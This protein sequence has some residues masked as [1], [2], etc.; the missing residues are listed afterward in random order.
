MRLGSDNNTLG[1]D[2]VVGEQVVDRSGKYII[3]IGA[4]SAE[5]FQDLLNNKKHVKFIQAVSNV[6][7]A[8]PLQCDIVLVLDEGAAQPACLGESAYS[9]LGQST[10]LVSPTNKQT[11]S[12]VL[13]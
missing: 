6:F 8:Q 3:R 10:W 12:V 9:N 4:L 1:G 2:S 11:F 5:Q 7:L 13:N